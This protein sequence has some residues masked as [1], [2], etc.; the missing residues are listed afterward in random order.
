MVLRIIRIYVLYYQPD[1]S[2]PPSI[3]APTSK[4]FHMRQRPTRRPT[5]SP[6]PTAHPAHPAAVPLGAMLLAGSLGAWAQATDPATEKRL[7]TVTVQE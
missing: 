1:T 7:S 6:A 4:N 2:H 3:P 5:G